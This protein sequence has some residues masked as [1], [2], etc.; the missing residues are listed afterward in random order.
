MPRVMVVVVGMPGSGKTSVSRMLAGMADAPLYVMGDV[1]RER[2][3]EKG[4]EASLEN[5]M[6]EAQL[7]RQELG[8]EGV[9][10]LLSRR[11]KREGR[12]R[13]VVDGARGPEEL[14]VLSRVA[15]CMR[16]VAVVASPHTRLRRLLS[17]GREGDPKSMRELAERDRRE[18]S[19]GLGTL[20][21]LADHTLVNEEGVGELEEQVRRLARVVWECNG[22]SEWRYL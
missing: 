16:V 12:E 18:L 4:L 20:I 1:V 21:A 3:Q 2:L 22:E 9:A 6:R 13:V 17:R 11:L 5:L 14:R 19:F 8:P 15:D 10:I 7:I